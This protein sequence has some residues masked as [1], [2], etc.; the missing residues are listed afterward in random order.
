MRLPRL[1]P[2]GQPHL[3]PEARSNPTR[4]RTPLASCARTRPPS[5]PTRATRQCAPAPA[6]SPG[7]TGSQVSVS[8]ENVVLPRR[9]DAYIRLRLTGSPVPE[10]ATA[11]TGAAVAMPNLAPAAS[12]A[13]QSRP[14]PLSPTAEHPSAW[15]RSLGGVPP[16]GYDD[17]GTP[18]FDAFLG[19]MSS[20]E[21]FRV[22]DGERSAAGPGRDVTEG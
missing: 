18:P 7:R 12:N 17:V 6:R 22:D 3:L 15:V 13:A 10:P 19:D 20:P 16:V 5:Q 8:I 21:P 14:A 9:L 4:L 2:W 11:S 1:S